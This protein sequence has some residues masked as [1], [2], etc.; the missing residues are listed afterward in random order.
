LVG[1]PG[2]GVEAFSAALDRTALA[3]VSEQA[4]G[5]RRAV[6]MATEYAKTRFQFGR[7]IGSFQAV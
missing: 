6:E 1:K 5:A 7:A 2:A 4:G 3:L